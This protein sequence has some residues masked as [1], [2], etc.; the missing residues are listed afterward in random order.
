MLILLRRDL[1]RWV[2]FRLLYLL[3]IAKKAISTGVAVA[4]AFTIDPAKA[5]FAEYSTNLNAVQTILANTQASGATLKDVNAALDELNTYSDKTIYNF[6][7][8]ARNIGTFTAAG[9]DLK[10]ATAVDQGYR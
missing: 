7:Q 2:S 8:M 5:G 10:T 9:V 1:L 4:K 6:S 3:E